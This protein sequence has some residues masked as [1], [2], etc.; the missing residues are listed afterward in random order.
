M[1]PVDGNIPINTVLLAYF[2]I[3]VLFSLVS[4]YTLYYMY[5]FK[6]LIAYFKRSSFLCFLAM[7]SVYKC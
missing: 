6:F 3:P 5:L 4:F 2:A 1:P 7:P